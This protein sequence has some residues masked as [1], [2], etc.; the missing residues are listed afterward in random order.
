MEKFGIFEKKLRRL[1]GRLGML[2]A[3][4]LIESASIGAYA[5]VM[6]WAKYDNGTLTI[7]I[8]KVVAPTVCRRG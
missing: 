1:V 5:K 3:F 8:C 4:L 7:T 6:P 2:M